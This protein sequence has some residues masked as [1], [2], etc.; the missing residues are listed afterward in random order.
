VARDQLRRAFREPGATYDERGIKRT[1]WFLEA[2]A[3]E[4][5]MEHRIL[6][7]LLRVQN[8]R[9]RK[10]GY[11]SYDPL[12]HASYEMR[13]ANATAYNHYDMTV[14]MLNKSMGTLLR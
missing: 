6:K 2:A 10:R 1:N 11:S 13:V 3:R 4:K 14:A 7:N 8:M 12:K 9:F 5:G